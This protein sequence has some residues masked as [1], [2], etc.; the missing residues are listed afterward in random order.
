ME[1]SDMDVAC[2]QTI[3]HK[4]NQLV[5]RTIDM[6]LRRL[7]R[8]LLFLKCSMVAILKTRNVSW[9]HLDSNVPTL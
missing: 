5:T 6:L 7:S 2:G 1:Q 8:A 4:S 3:G 9:Q